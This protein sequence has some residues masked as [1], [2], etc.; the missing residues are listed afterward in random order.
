MKG[1]YRGQK[2]NEAKMLADQQKYGPE[3]EEIRTQNSFEKSE[4]RIL[5]KEVWMKVWMMKENI[6]RENKTSISR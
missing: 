6:I 3:Y 4:K 5:Q 1:C 2:S